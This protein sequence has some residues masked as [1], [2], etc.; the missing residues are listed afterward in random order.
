MNLKSVQQFDQLLI[1]ALHNPEQ[2]L[3]ITHLVIKLNLPDLPYEPTLL[4][5]SLISNLY[6]I[7]EDYQSNQNPPCLAKFPNAFV[8]VAK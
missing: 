3:L 2:A 4:D 8:E 5:M 6:V 7:W 1:W